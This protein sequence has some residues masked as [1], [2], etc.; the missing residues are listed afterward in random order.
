MTNRDY[1]QLIDGM[2]QLYAELVADGDE[3]VDDE[4]GETPAEMFDEF[5]DIIDAAREVLE[6]IDVA[7]LPEV[8][9]FDELEDRVEDEDLTKADLLR[10]V[11]HTDLIDAVDLTQLAKE[12]DELEDEVD[13]VTDAH[14]A[15][16]GDEE[17]TGESAEDGESRIQEYQH[18]LQELDQ[19]ELE[20]ALQDSLMDAVE[21]F[22]AALLETHATFQQLYE[23]NQERFDS[24]GEKQPRSLNP[25][26]YSTLPSRNQSMVTTA[27]GSTVPRSAR[28]SR[29]ENERRI[30]GP[31][32]DQEVDD[33]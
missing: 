19:E 4:D 28:H 3:L 21:K 32:F 22:R 2:N 6:T 18:S 9:D 26:A 11:D 33:E 31:R 8:I 5:E 16:L 10:S 24:A 20:L 29:I 14:K 1:D 23:E 12:A 25:T 17:E 13:D 27:I 15:I 7:K 30:Y